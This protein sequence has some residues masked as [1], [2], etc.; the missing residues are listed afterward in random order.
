[1]QILTF[2]KIDLICHDIV[3][4]SDIADNKY[5]VFK[6]MLLRTGCRPQELLYSHLWSLAP[7]GSLFLQPLKSNNPREF[8]QSELNADFYDSVVSN[9][10]IFF[11]GELRNYNRHWHLTYTGQHMRVDNGFITW[12]IFRHRYIKRLHE[13]GYSPQQIMSWTGHKK[14]YIVEGYINSAIWID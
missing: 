2:N 7:N 5:Q 6:D 14:Q 12:K 9:D 1:M 13:L 3:E 11:G 4:Y 10:F 8:Y